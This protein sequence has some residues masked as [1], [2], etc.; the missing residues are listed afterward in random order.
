MYIRVLKSKLHGLTVTHTLLDYEG[1]VEIDQDWMEAA[2]LLEGEEVDVLNLSTG[3]RI[4]TYAIAGARGSKVVCLNGPAARTGQ[5][6]DPVIVLAYAL[7]TPEEA[8]GFRAVKL[9]V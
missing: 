5:P 2:N 1:S 4:T 6:G 9:K 8:R 3:S 7:M